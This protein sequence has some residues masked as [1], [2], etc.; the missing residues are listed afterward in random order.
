M[1][2]ILAFSLCDKSNIISKQLRT[3]LI[4]EIF[5]YFP[6][7]LGGEPPGGGG[8]SINSSYRVSPTGV[9][10]LSNRVAHFSNPVWWSS[11]IVGEDSYH[12]QKT[13]ITCFKITTIEKKFFWKYK[14]IFF[15]AG[16]K[17]K[18]S[19]APLSSAI[20]FLN[21]PPCVQ[22]KTHADSSKTL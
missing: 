16:K 18:I 12:K 7:L 14:S 5:L 10:Q 1:R 3:L 22:V 19:K 17:Y 6:L 15:P 9:W 21:R 20:Y 11:K 8:S 2:H 13:E 4:W